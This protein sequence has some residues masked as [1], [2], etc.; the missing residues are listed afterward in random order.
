MNQVST[1]FFSR[2]R[3]DR[4]KFTILDGTEVAGPEEVLNVDFNSDILQK[5]FC[6]PKLG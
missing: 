1:R 4:G 3:P 5:I 2:S 6:D